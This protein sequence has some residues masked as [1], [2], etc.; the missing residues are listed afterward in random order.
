MS[1][2]TLYEELRELIDCGSESMTHEG[3]VE[4]IVRLQA[5][6]CAHDDLLAALEEALDAVRDCCTNHGG[7]LGVYAHAQIRAARAAIAK[8][9]GNPN[10]QTLHQLRRLHPRRPQACRLDPESIGL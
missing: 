6:D 3:A 9:K 4:E 1:Y 7:K 2:N 10:A 8:A 5:V